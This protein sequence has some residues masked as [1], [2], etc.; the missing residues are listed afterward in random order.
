MLRTSS[1]HGFNI[2]GTSEKLVAAL[3][4]DDTSTFLSHRDKWSDLWKILDTWCKASRAKFNDKKTEI[5]P[6]GSPEYRER[7]RKQRTIN[8]TQEEDKIEETVRIAEEGE[9]IRVLGAWI[10]NGVENAA[11]WTPII[12][13]IKTFLQRWNQ[14]RPTLAGKV[15]IVQMG[16][17]GLT[18]YLTRVQG[19]P[20]QT[21]KEIEKIIRTFIWGHD[22]TPPISMETLHKPPAEGGLGL[23]DICSRNE[24][25]QL[26]WAKRYLDFS[27]ERPT[28]AYALDILIGKHTLKTAGEIPQKAQLNT[29][30][31][32]WNPATHAR[33]KL[34]EY[35]K[36]MIKTAKKNNVNIAAIKL[37]KTMKTR[38]P[39]WYH[40]G[41]EKHLRKLNNT[42]ISKCLRNNH[43]VISVAA[44]IDTIK[45]MGG[46]N[47]PNNST[48]EPKENC[49]CNTCKRAKEKG[50]K[51]PRKCRQAAQK[52]LHHLPS[53]WNPEA[54]TPGDGLTLTKKRITENIHALQQGNKITF[55]PTVTE[56]G[57]LTEAFRVFTEDQAI[58]R[59]PALRQARGR[60]VEEETTSVWI[61]DL[62]DK[63]P[64]E[65]TQ[66][67]RGCLAY[68]GQNDPR[69]AIITEPTTPT[70]GKNVKEIL[71]ASLYAAKN[72]PRDAPLNMKTLNPILR[73]IL[74]EK[75]KIWEEKGWIGIQIAPYVRA[76]AAT[77]R[78][79]CAIT[80]IEL[81][82]ENTERRTANRIRD[83]ARE[84]NHNE[85]PQKEHPP[86]DIEP[87]FNLTGAKLKTLTQA[88]AYK[89]IRESKSV[90][91]RQTT[92]R[93]LQ[94][95]RDKLEQQHYNAQD[96]VIWKGIRH[97]DI[98]RPIRDFMW[99][100]IHGAHKIGT[101]WTK[102]PNYEQ[103]AE[104]GKC[105]TLDSMEHILGECKAEGQQT[106]WT[107]AKRLWEK[108]GQKW[109]KPSSDDAILAS[110][111]TWK[112]P[113]TGKRRPGIERL[114]RILITESIY[115]IWKLRCERVI[116][117]EDEEWEHSKETVKAAW[118]SQ[119]TAR[120][121]LDLELIRRRYG[122]RAQQ[123]ATV[124]KT[125]TSVLADLESLPDDWTKQI[126][127][128]VGRMPRVRL[129]FDP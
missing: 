112:H 57:D 69:N 6:I 101:F 122:A 116:G 61:L 26:M 87:R 81:A 2:P 77:L 42:A 73:T 41:A 4:A 32:S 55:D 113:T 115:M 22:R 16:A 12:K 47:L 120:L 28:W 10:G 111:Q 13:K 64:K 43:D 14:C 126:G 63:K 56:R 24:A 85:I 104:C 39:I 94:R 54:P 86:L 3:F 68:F 98:R 59:P 96:E 92:E 44:L 65:G 89:G 100:T 128:L 40:I 1:L 48:E 82:K 71:I 62:H 123:R 36:E 124:L 66:E 51:H 110:T 106:I 23:L 60:T 25:L 76:L 119:I 52:L 18:Q 58:N 125:W 105:K 29:F 45:G 99:K 114:W 83:W 9:P 75:L 11:V 20:K 53:K 50:C 129:N 121:H 127:F 49:A 72:T 21:E 97:K 19:M 90:K 79:R 5:I 95:L 7:V 80:T 17:G 84:T 91:P 38:M 30:L 37:D 93:N 78:Q 117:K 34:P 108:T 70:S 107:E 88:L 8:P 118:R 102:I 74:N 33:S 15:H 67:R 109:I 103:R 35:A 31:Q 27:S 46:C